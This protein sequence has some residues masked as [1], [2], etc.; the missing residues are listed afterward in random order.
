MGIT[1]AHSN[2]PGAG[3]GA[4]AMKDFPK[5]TF[6]GPYTGERHRSTERANQSGYVSYYSR[7]IEI[8]SDYVSNRHGLL[9]MLKVMSTIISMQVIHVE[10][11]G[12]GKVKMQIQQ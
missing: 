6:F 3:L 12:F 1:I 10:V 5:N 4:F 8:G 9:K 7:T 2:I 11:I